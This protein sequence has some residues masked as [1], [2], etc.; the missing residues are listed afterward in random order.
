LVFDESVYFLDIVQIAFEN[1]YKPV[2][3][4]RFD[5]RETPEKRTAISE[6]FERAAGA[7]VM[8]ILRATGGVGL[9]IMSANVVILCGPW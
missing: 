1:I 8:L 3:C 6:E 2:Q 5:G 9:N 7:K 4:L